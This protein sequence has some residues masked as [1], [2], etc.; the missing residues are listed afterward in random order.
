MWVCGSKGGVHI[1]VRV[2][3]LVFNCVYACVSVSA[4]VHVFCVH[5]LLFCY[6]FLFKIC[7]PV[8]LVVGP[9]RSDF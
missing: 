5:M 9:F 3:V 1:C 4:C 2:H 7:L 8:D 6:F